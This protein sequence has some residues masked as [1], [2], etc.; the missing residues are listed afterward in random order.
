MAYLLQRGIP[1]IPTLLASSTLPVVAATVQWRGMWP[2][3]VRKKGPK[4]TPPQTDTVKETL[5]CYLLEDVPKIGA[6][7]RVLKVKPGTFRYTLQ[8]NK[9]ARYAT[10]EEITEEK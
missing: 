4:F 7:G 2:R 10:V 6:K 9:Q 5:Y 3:M 1:L 8:P